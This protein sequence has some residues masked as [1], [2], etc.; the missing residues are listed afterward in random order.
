MQTLQKYSVVAILTLSIVAGLFNNIPSFAQE[1]NQTTA[2]MANQTQKAT[3]K[4]YSTTE[5]GHSA[6]DE[7]I[8]RNAIISLEI[9]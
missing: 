6:K 4:Q 9:S 5:T 8:F 2:P 7:G 3:E 1:G